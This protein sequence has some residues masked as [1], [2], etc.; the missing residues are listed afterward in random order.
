MGVRKKGRDEFGGNYRGWGRR[1]NFVNCEKKEI[2][3]LAT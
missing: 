1:V 2:E 3:G